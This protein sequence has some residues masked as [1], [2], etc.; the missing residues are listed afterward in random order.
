MTIANKTKQPLPDFNQIKLNEIESRLD[1]LLQHNRTQLAN[2]LK[3][4]EYSWAQL[5]HPLEDLDVILNNTWALVSH[6]NN[7]MNTKELREIYANCVRKLT[8]YQTEIGQNEQLYQAYQSI[9]ESA[10]FKNLNQAQQKT[11]TDSLRDFKLAGVHLPPQK[12]QRYRQ[13]Q[14]RLVELATKFEENLLDATDNWSQLITDEQQIEGV[15]EHAKSAAIQLA[16]DKGQI[17]WLFNLE[18]PSYIAIMMHAHNRALREEFYTAFVTRASEVGPNAGRWD[19]TDVM[20]EI[21][22]LR[23]ELAKLLDFNNYAELSLATKMAES[24]QQVLGFLEELATRSYP[25]AKE[26]Y[27]ELTDFARNKHGLSELAAWDIAYYSEQLR[28]QKYAI[29]QEALRPYFPENKVFQGLFAICRKLYG[30]NIIER[31]GELNAWHKDVR[32]FDIFDRNNNIIAGIYLDLYARPQK[33]GGAWIDSCRDRHRYLNNELQLPI[34]FLTTNI[35]GP[36]ETSPALLTHDDVLTLFHEFGHGL[37]H[38]LTK[39]EN[40]SVSG[41][42]GVAWDAVE[43]PSQF[44]E[45]WCWQKEALDLISGHYQTGDKLPNDLFE[46]MYAAKN[47]QSGIQMVRQ[48]E[49]AIFDFRLHLEYDP[50]HPTNIQQLIEDVRQQVAV[51]PSPDFNR[52]P[53]CFS[54]IFAGGYAA[55]YY[56]YKWAEVLSCDAFEQF[57]ELG[58]FNPELGERFETT[59]LQQG[60]SKEA[61]DIFVEFMGRKPKLDALLKDSG[62]ISGR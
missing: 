21:I 58:I 46:R 33:R 28:Q 54:H 9:A 60:G 35:M 31:G 47:F 18:Y 56:S 24:P 43:F 23:H 22:A 37:H 42:N 12:K 13:I 40:V 7:V 48:L 61:M 45:H 10:N 29:S 19:N 25:Y 2:L 32:Y 51:I 50:E 55:G 39:I 57:S 41:I 4:G 49:Y 14:E 8:E 62:M 1:K 16:K 34:A 6:L 15:S 36:T 3:Q 38:M 53:N 17:G 20:H 44:M 27:A 52:F 30:V 59:V 26:D 5:I 11:I